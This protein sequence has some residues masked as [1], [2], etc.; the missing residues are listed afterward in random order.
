M[1]KLTPEQINTQIEWM[2]NY[3]GAENAASG[4]KLDANANVTNKN[5]ATLDAEFSK[6]YKIQVNRELIRRR[7]ES[8]FGEATATQYVKDLESHLIYTHDETSLAPYCV[9]ITMYPFL[10]EGMKGLDGDSDA[11]NHLTSFCGNF[12]NLAFAVASQFAGAVATVEYLMCFDYFARK[13]YGDNY[14]D[15]N[16]SDV[17]QQ[18][19]G[20]VYALNQPAAAR[21]FQS[22]FWN[23]STFDKYF[24]EGIFGDFMF[25]DATK[26]DWDTLSKLQEAF[27]AW[28]REERTKK[29]LTFPVVTHA[30]I[31]N[32]DATDW[33]DEESADFIAREMAKGG[34]FF[35]YTSPTADSLAS[36]CR[37]RNE[38]QDNTFSYSL[39][40]GGTATGS[41]N[42]ITINMNRL[43]QEGHK[44][45]DVIKRVQKYQVAFDDHFREWQEDGLLPVYDA[46]FISLDKQYLTLGLN[47][48]TEAAEYLGYEISNNDEYKTWLADTFGAFK[49]LNKEAKLEYDLMFNTEIVPAENLG[50]KNAKW[51]KADGLVVPRDCY[52]SYMYIVEDSVNIIDKMELHG[53]GIVTNLDGGSA[54]HFNNDKRANA[55]VYRVLL[56]SLIT[57]G[58]NYFCENVPKTCC[59]ECGSITADNL[60]ACPACGSENIDYATRV[61]GY[62]KRV[63]A[64]SGERQ[65]EE[66][67]RKYGYEPSL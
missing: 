13:D 7:I 34:E 52:N 26:P 49:K 11:P 24:F 47:G 53:D 17:M 50:V 5:I 61:I 51:D 4:S 56:T 43:V 30:A 59:N 29:L 64:F 25:P 67:N 39:G 6:G 54:L 2:E 60:K 46:G 38:L 41:K 12:V 32:E 36:C 45:E 28:F 55:T 14:L 33:K 1:V 66:E 42:V 10:I 20:V 3:I 44:L 58:C 21:G 15:T 9:S 19:Q 40:A 27:H 63:K 8:R 16:Y 23:I 48:V 31:A 22:I 65:T 37:V 57:T 62:L 18:M 35:I